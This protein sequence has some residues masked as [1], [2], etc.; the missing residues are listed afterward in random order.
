MILRRLDIAEVRTRKGKLH[1]CVGIDR[2]SKLAFAK[3]HDKG[4]RPTAVAFLEPLES[5]VRGS[6]SYEY[7]T[8]IWTEPRVTRTRP[9][10]LL[11]PTKPLSHPRRRHEL[12]T[13]AMQAKPGGVAARRA[14][15]RRHAHPLTRTR[16]HAQGQSRHPTPPFSDQPCPPWRGPG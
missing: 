5:F 3:L 10:P 16:T 8:R 15:H 7:V 1:R 13:V 9:A 6:H 4:D 12:V 2:T 14:K 11:F